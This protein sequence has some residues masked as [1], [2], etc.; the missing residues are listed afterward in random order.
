MT[1]PLVP[2]TKFTIYPV[3]ACGHPIIVQVGVKGAV[4][5]FAVLA[6]TIPEADA[7]AEAIRTAAHAVA[8]SRGQAD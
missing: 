7:I 5:G 6:L 4:E 8:K 3:A 2:H 1:A